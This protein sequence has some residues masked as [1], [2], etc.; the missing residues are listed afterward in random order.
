[1]KLRIEF[2]TPAFLYGVVQRKSEFRIPSLVGQMRYWWRMTRD[3]YNVVTL[4]N[5]EAKVFGLGM[6]KRSP[7]ICG[8]FQKISAGPTTYWNS[9]EYGA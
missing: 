5:D 2:L 8:R 1:M 9:T 3:W 6:K 4:R 7:S